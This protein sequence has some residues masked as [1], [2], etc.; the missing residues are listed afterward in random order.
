MSDLTPAQKP[1]DPDGCGQCLEACDTC[2]RLNEVLADAP[3]NPS[4]IVEFWGE[5]TK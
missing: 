5:V 3:E 4:N 1:K 2:I